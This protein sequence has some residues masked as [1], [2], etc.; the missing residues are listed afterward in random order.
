[1]PLAGTSIHDAFRERRGCD[2]TVIGRRP[3]WFFQE[4]SMR[5]FRE[6]P[7]RSGTIGPTLPKDEDADR[8]GVRNEVHGDRFA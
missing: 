4:A 7:D 1:M 8:Q 2:L 3:S 6:M 5:P